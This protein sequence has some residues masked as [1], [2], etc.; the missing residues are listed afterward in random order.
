MSEMTAMRV[1][2]LGTLAALWVAVAVLL[3]RTSVP[4]LDEPSLEAAAIFGAH[5]L[6]R[7]AR[8]E[9][10]LTGLWAAGTLVLLG[11]L[12]LAA[13]W[14]PRLRLPPV[15]AGALLGGGVFLLVWLVR[16]PFHLAAHW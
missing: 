2:I 5:T 10:V 15:L 9:N 12:W 8:Y 6:A 3:W 4:A 14:A 16:L 7:N 11:A 1:G 13:R